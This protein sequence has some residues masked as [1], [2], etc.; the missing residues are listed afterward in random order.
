[1]R[2]E[3]TL[4]R[5]YTIKRKVK[6][7]HN[8]GLQTQLDLKILNFRVTNSLSCFIISDLTIFFLAVLF[9]FFFSLKA[10]LLLPQR[11]FRLPFFFFFFP[12]RFSVPFLP[13]F[14]LLIQ[15]LCWP[16]VSF[17]FLPFVSTLLSS[18]SWSR[19]ETVLCSRYF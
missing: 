8:L 2:K 16:R 18:F 3:Q 11:R 5:D 10:Y 9:L 4:N 14:D 6:K 17:F 7:I 1:M 12:S 13:F 15:T 19:K